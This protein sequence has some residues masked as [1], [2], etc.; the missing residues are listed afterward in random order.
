MDE[1]KQWIS[2]LYL[3]PPREYPGGVFVLEVSNGG[4]AHDA[5]NR[6]NLV[7]EGDNR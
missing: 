4:A 2:S 6:V 7:N 1:V 5:R 3:I